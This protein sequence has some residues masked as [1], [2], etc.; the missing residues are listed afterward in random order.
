M[1]IDGDAPNVIDFGATETDAGALEH[2]IDDFEL[3][4]RTEPPEPAASARPKSTVEERF[5]QAVMRLRLYYGWSQRDLQRTCGVHQSQ[6]SR[7]E[8]GRQ[9]G[10]SSRR[11]FAILRAL[12][13]GEIAFLPPPTGPQTPLEIML[14]GDPWER[15]GRAVER[16]VSRRRSA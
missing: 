13:V 3:D 15:A 12:R 2:D 8:S 14:F 16:R 6:I 10:L 9:R 11:I 7:L 5:G 1:T 4:W